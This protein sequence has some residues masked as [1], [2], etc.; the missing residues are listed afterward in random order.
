[1]NAAQ[2]PQFRT[3]SVRVPERPGAESTY[4]RL[5][6]RLFLLAV[7]FFAL[8]FAFKLLTPFL[9]P[10]VL[11]IVLAALFSPLQNLIT[12]YFRGRRS[13]AA[14]VMVLLIAGLLVVPVLFIAASMTNQGI[15]LT[16]Q[17]RAWIREGNLTHIE[18]HELIVSSIAWIKTKF[19]FIPLESFDPKVLLLETSRYLSEWFLRHGADLLG[20]LASTLAYFGVMLFILFYLLRDGPTLIKRIKF[21]S[22]LR[23]AQEDRILSKVRSV[24]RSVLV[25][26]LLT[27]MLQ[28]LVGGIGLAI[29]GVPALFWGSMMAFASLIPVVG[30]SLIWLPAAGYLVIIGSWKAAAFLILW[31]VVIVSSID[32]FLKP[33]LMQGEGGMS[34]FYIFLAILGGL[35][36]FGLAGILYGPLIIAFATVM[37]S[38]YEDEF[39][40][41]L[42]E[43]KTQSEVNAFAAARS[44]SKR[45]KRRVK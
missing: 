25:G 18:Q 29:V 43:K 17:I 1:M 15:I 35:Q 22:P 20:N 3:T 4:H 44:R 27:A 8:G 13:L 38:I 14:L 40:A 33:F 21:L 30:T 6:A 23:E 45:P 39:K 19:P 34:P 10:I 37:L 31:S 32:S 9:N 24:S 2:H 7:L 41:W 36:L 28:G 12:K 11:G 42:E 26:S 5:G 16:T